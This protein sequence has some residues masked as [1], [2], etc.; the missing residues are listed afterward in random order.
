MEKNTP[1]AHGDRGMEK[2]G[3]FQCLDNQTVVQVQHLIA[4]HSLTLES[5]AIIAALAFGSAH[6]G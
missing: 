1:A 4:R 6:H 5:A 2:L 3:G